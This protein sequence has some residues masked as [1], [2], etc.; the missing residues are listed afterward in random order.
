MQ[1]VHPT[2]RDR[3]NTVASYKPKNL[4]TYLNGTGARVY[5]E[6]GD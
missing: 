5:G 3:F 2:A 4:A 1:S 6:E